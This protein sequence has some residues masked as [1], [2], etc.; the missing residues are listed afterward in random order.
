MV[1]GDL[2]KKLIF[3]SKYELKSQKLKDERRKEYYNIRNKKKRL[4]QLRFLQKIKQKQKE[5][6]LKKIE[7]EKEL[8]SNLLQVALK[9][10]R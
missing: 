6:R 9:K 5:E 3:P 2:N 7:K 8:I 10:I 4:K 1:K